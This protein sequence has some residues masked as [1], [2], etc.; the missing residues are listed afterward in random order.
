M[1][2]TKEKVTGGV[3]QI[4]VHGYKFTVDTDLI[5][6]VDSL[7]YLERIESKGEIGAV[8]PLLKHIMGV[9]EYNKLK[10]YMI[11]KDGDDHAADV[12]AGKIVPEKDAPAYR[13]RMRME[14]L[15]D[16]YLAI[17]EKFD[18]KG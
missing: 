17:L 6:D 14:K 2:D 13:P 9:P 15:Q 1:A 10:D 5:D 7:E 3:Q 8:L 4:E 12:K 18:P 11:K 16:V